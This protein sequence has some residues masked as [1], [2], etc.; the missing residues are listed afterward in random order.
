MSSLLSLVCGD[1]IEDDDEDDGDYVDDGGESSEED[2]AEGDSEG[3]DDDGSAEGEDDGDDVNKSVQQ[4]RKSKKH[5]NHT[6]ACRRR[7]QK[8]C[9]GERLSEHC[10]GC[11]Y[12][13]NYCRCGC[14]AFSR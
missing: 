10:I 7:L 9:D 13:C 12:R 1:L 4:K 14:E 8:Y 2:Y 3:D 6:S 5:V 11:H